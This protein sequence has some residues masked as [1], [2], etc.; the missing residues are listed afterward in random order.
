MMSF[1]M[2]LME[3]HNTETCGDGVPVMMGMVRGL[4]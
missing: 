2:R 4:W 1:V 3:G